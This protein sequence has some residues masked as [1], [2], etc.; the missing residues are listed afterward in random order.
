M[1]CIFC[2]CVWIPYIVYLLFSVFFVYS[3]RFYFAFMCHSN[4]KLKLP[5]YF[6]TNDSFDFNCLS[7]VHDS[8]LF[9][10]VIFSISFLFHD[11]NVVVMCVLKSVVLLNKYALGIFVLF[12]LVSF[13]ICREKLLNANDL[14]WVRIW[15]T[16]TFRHW[17]WQ[18]FLFLFWWFFFHISC[19]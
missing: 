11:M 8:I 1:C 3:F 7:L 15:V 12:C 6:S 13:T 5:E 17:R 18:R 14:I 2:V 9:F 10:F 19:C 16:A 4:S